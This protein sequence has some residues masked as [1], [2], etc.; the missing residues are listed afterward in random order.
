MRERFGG[1]DVIGP[2][3]FQPIDGPGVLVTRPPNEVPRPEQSGLR[4]DSPESMDMH[5]EVDEHAGA[6]LHADDDDDEFEDRIRTIRAGNRARLRRMRRRSLTTYRPGQVLRGALFNDQDHNE[7]E[8]EDGDS[9]PEYHVLDPAA[10]A[11]Y[12]VDEDGNH[13][14]EAYWRTDGVSDDDTDPSDVDDS[15][16]MDQD[17]NLPVDFHTEY[18]VPRS[19]RPGLRLSDHG[20]IEV[21]N[22]DIFGMN[23]TR[24]S[25]NRVQQYISSWQNYRYEEYPRRISRAREAVSRGSMANALVFRMSEAAGRFKDRLGGV[26]DGMGG[27]HNAEAGP[28]SRPAANAGDSVQERKEAREEA[29][30]NPAIRQVTGRL[31]IMQEREKAESPPTG[32]SIAGRMDGMRERS[33]EFARASG[34]M[35]RTGRAEQEDELEDRRV[36]SRSSAGRSEHGEVNHPLDS[37]PESGV[38][39][40]GPRKEMQADGESLESNDTDDIASGGFI[41]NEMASRPSDHWT[42]AKDDISIETGSSQTESSSPSGLGMPKDDP[43]YYDLR[44]FPPLIAIDDSTDSADDLSSIANRLVGFFRVTMKA[45]HR[46]VMQAKFGVSYDGRSGDLTVPEGERGTTW[47]TC[48]TMNRV[49]AD[50]DRTLEQ[51]ASAFSSAVSTDLDLMK[52]ALEETNRDFGMNWDAFGGHPSSSCSDSGSDAIADRNH[53]DKQDREIDQLPVPRSEKAK[54]RIDGELV[55]S[56]MT[57]F[58]S[59]ALA[60]YLREEYQDFVYSSGDVYLDRLQRST[61][62]MQSAVFVRVMMT[63]AINMALL[64]HDRFTHRASRYKSGGELS[65]EVEQAIEST[66][67]SADQVGELRGRLRPLLEAADDESL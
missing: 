47:A 22:E 46:H 62:G 52:T 32:R 42:T 29:D 59:G 44:V 28:S 16:A 41:D 33:E 65:Q 67:G 45:L 55:Y 17:G 49:N 25:S 23:R 14:D 35:R 9:N 56:N 57:N 13:R 43:H 8:D 7:D 39:M 2:P 3:T 66:A 63:Y 15:P 31:N 30:F 27:R 1:V 4:S 51:R 38:A 36:G 50:F 64:A 5:E 19:G 53:G 24:Y 34:R 12:A 54:L 10:R 26:L 21:H 58:I 60:Y 61:F 11:V 48:R 40:E 6:G 20:H 37:Q 18:G